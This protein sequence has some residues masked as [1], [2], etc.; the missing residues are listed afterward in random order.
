MVRA[1][2]L[3]RIYALTLA[4]HLKASALLLVASVAVCPCILK[5]GVPSEER[6]FLPQFK[7]KA[8][9]VIRNGHWFA[10]SGHGVSLLSRSRS[11]PLP[12][13]LNCRGERVHNDLREQAAEQSIDLRD[14]LTGDRG[15]HVSQPVIHGLCTA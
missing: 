11:R 12:M 15:L 9:V 8:S 10:F 4:P 2:T 1:L 14:I 3:L 7:W 6:A 5:L 13:G